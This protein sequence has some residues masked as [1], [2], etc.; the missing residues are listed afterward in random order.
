MNDQCLNGKLGLAGFVKLSGWLE[1][2]DQLSVW[3]TGVESENRYS[4][5]EQALVLSREPVFLVP[6]ILIKQRTRPITVIGNNIVEKN[7]QSPT[8]LVIFSRP[9]I[10]KNESTNNTICLLVKTFAFMSDFSSRSRKFF[11][12]KATC[13]SRNREAKTTM[14]AVHTANINPTGRL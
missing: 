6:K 12:F 3:H 13:S 11:I 7:I 14:K 2:D 9:P 10:R 8:V 4:S 1:L 5:S